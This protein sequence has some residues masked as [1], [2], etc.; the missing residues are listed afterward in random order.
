MRADLCSCGSGRTFSRCHGDP[1]NEFARVQALAEA[2]QIAVLFPSVRLR[3]KPAFAFAERVAND[4]PGA[5]RLPEKLLDKGLASAGSHERREVVD[6]WVD[7][8]PD[9]WA[10][11]TGAAA[12]AGA[13]ERELVRGALE[14][15]VAERQP[16]PGE[17]LVELDLGRGATP[18]A[19]LALVLPPPYVWSYDEALAAGAAA[20]GRRR[21]RAPGRRGRRLEGG[22]DSPL[23]RR[24]ATAAA[25]ARGGSALAARRLLRRGETWTLLRR[26]GGH[27]DG[28][29]FL[30]RL[31]HA[32]RLRIEFATSEL[33][34]EALRWLRR[35][36]ERAYS[37]V[38][39]TSFALMR[40]LRIREALAF[41][42]DFAAAG[43]VELRA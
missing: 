39:A 4:F 32:P 5:E 43:F 23:R 1:R 29:F 11:L 26:R 27:R 12:D 24:A 15:A 10:S 18:A 2:R 42:G 36:D 8:Y 9:R 21:P 38:D 3:S 13:A 37:F 25:A 31:E 28:V 34:S 20:P 30:D 6:S 33:E 17:L 14:V 22:P 35:H 16:T 41:D 40:K 7:E 19:A